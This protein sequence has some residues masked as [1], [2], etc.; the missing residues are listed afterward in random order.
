MEGVAYKDAGA[1]LPGVHGQTQLES[2]RGC[3]GALQTGDLE[4]FHSLTQSFV[5]CMLYPKQI[6]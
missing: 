3:L 4:P 2:A 6:Q 1:S 5:N